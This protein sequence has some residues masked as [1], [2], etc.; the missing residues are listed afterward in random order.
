VST[1]LGTLKH[2]AGYLFIMRL[3]H[4]RVGYHLHMPMFPQFKTVAGLS[5]IVLQEVAQFGNSVGL[6]I[7]A[8]ITTGVSEQS[9]TADYEERP[10]QDFRAAFRSVFAAIIVL[11]AFGLRKRGLRWKE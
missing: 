8:S 1:R 7:A 6:A 9:G 5:K 10:I 2:L 11:T 4:W 3:S